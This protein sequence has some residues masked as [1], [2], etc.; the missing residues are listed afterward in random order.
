MFICCQGTRVIICRRKNL[1]LLKLNEASEAVKCWLA[2]D[3]SCS[4]KFRDILK[5]WLLFKSVGPKFGYFPEAT[6][7]WLIVKPD[8]FE[9]VKSAFDRTDINVT[10]EGRKHLGAILGSRSYPE[11]YV[12]NKVKTWVQ[13]ILKLSEFAMSQPQAA[14]AAFS[15]GVRHKWTYCL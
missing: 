7:C 3:A 5:W 12:R 4:G 2:D 9:E 6:M 15:F 11:E 1:E 14:Y 8:K 13:E 10:C